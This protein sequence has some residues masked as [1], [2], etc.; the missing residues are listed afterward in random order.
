[1]PDRENSTRS[2]SNKEIKDANQDEAPWRSQL[3]AIRKEIDHVDET[4]SSL[5]S[6]RLDLVRQIGDIK[7]KHNLPTLDGDRE[8]KVLE[9]VL[10]NASDSASAHAISTIYEALLRLSKEYQK[11]RRTGLAAGETH[12]EQSSA[13][14]YFPSVAIIGLGAIGGSMAALIKRRLSQTKIT[15]FDPSAESSRMAKDHGVVDDLAKDAVSA[16]EGAS[17]VILAANPEANLELL[18]QIAPALKQGQV[19]ID[20]T[21]AKSAICSLAEKTE[22]GGAEFIGGHPFYGTERS[23][24]MAA[25]NIQPEHRIFCLVPSKKSSPP[26]VAKLAKWLAALNLRAEVIDSYFHDALVARASHVPQLLSSLLGSQ[27]QRN[28]NHEGLSRLSLASFA[29]FQAL[30]RLMKSPAPMWKEIVHQNRDEVVRAL[31]EI[32]EGLDEL[33]TGLKADDLTEMDRIFDEAQK[34]AKA[35]EENPI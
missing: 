28:F 25:S 33:L 2:S 27:L 13:A 23:G 5:I 24:F 15:G 7:S 19:V 31:T 26:T 21:S 10:G 6:A 32:Q 8:K 18:K 34:T 17:L 4:I 29:T 1:M 14:E 35:I 3:D 22:M 16:V 20:V 30:T 12:G 9:H 11:E